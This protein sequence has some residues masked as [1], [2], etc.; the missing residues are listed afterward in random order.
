[1]F[2]GLTG[3]PGTGKTSV[4]RYLGSHIG[5]KVIHLTELIKNEKLYCQ[6]DEKRDTLVVD[7]EKVAEYLENMSCEAGET[8]IL[9]SH[10]AHHIADTAIVLRAH[11]EILRQRLSQRSYSPEKVQENIEAEALDVILV[12]AFEWCKDVFEINTTHMSLEKV[13]GSVDEIIRTLISGKQ[14]DTLDKYKPGSVD[15]SEEF[16]A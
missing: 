1:M 10:M 4:S 2:I 8:I 13:A 15:W 5:Y 12:E 14:R 7:M 9:E 6:R 11:P 3:T 16:F